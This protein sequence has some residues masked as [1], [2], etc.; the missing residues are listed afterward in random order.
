MAV[1]NTFEQ[2][3]SNPSNLGAVNVNKLL[4]PDGTKYFNNFFNTPITISSA[5][6]DAILSYF[7]SIAQNKD[8]ALALAS[9]VIYTS[10]VQGIDVMLVLDEFKK[11]KRE[12]TSVLIS[13][14]LNLSRVGTSL[15][16]VQ[17]NQQR[18]KYV[19]RTILA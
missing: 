7:E 16:G 13:Y 10:R 6:D 2:L 12:D 1:V 18:N 5:K 3:K 17:K 8:A 15:I 9:A 11:L 19:A 4:S 14:F